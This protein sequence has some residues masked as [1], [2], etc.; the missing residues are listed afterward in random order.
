MCVGVVNLGI[1]VWGK[2]IFDFDS[3][4]EVIRLALDRKLVPAIN[5]TSLQALNGT[6]WPAFNDTVLSALDVTAGVSLSAFNAT[7]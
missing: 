5:A 2:L 3:L 7:V 6:S 1:N 4:P